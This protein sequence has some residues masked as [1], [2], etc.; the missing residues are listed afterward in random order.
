M[1]CANNCKS[2]HNY[3]YGAILPQMMKQRDIV[4]KNKVGNI[5]LNDE[6]KGYCLKK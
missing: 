1:N 5:A 2:I 4:L 6:T 3:K